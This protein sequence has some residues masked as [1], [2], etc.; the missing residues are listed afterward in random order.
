MLPS[1][2]AAKQIIVFGLFLIWAHWVVFSICHIVELKAEKSS[3]MNM[4]LILLEKL[5]V[6]LEPDA[7]LTSSPTQF[8]ETW[9][10]LR[11]GS[12]EGQNW[13]IVCDIMHGVM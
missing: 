10:F 9:G 5:W 4:A 2:K 8:G 6:S 3:S 1:H 13:E 12:R 7:T 11:V